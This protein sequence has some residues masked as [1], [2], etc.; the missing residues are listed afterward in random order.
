MCRQAVKQLK[1]SNKNASL[2]LTTMKY[3]NSGSLC[4]LLFNAT[5]PHKGGAESV[6][7][8]G[9]SW[10]RWTPAVAIKTWTEWVTMWMWWGWECGQ[11]SLSA[12]GRDGEE[13]GEED[14]EGAARRRLQRHTSLCDVVPKWC[15]EAVQL[16]LGR[17]LK[18]MEHY[19]MYEIYRF[20]TCGS[21]DGVL[22][23]F[24]FC[25]PSFPYKLR[26]KKV[27]TSK[28]AVG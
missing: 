3:A 7:T 11:L 10:W 20:T 4:L 26:R 6:T 18:P 22:M 13:D 15:G 9:I 1:E 16:C 14:G 8:A 17:F 12:E 2:R 19:K 5:S 21:T 24:I 23:G 25:T 28:K 27:E